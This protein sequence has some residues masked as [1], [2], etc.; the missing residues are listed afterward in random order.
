MRNT[1]FNFFLWWAVIGFSIWL[2]GTLFSMSVIV[3]MWSESPPESVRDFFGNTSF[4]TYIYNFFGPPWMAARNLPLLIALVLGWPSLPHRRYL[5]FAVLPLI[6]GILF[7]LFYIYPINEILMT[8]AGD[9]RSADE[10]QA[11]ADT[12]IFAD[13]LRFGIMLIGYY[14][15]LKAFKLP[16]PLPGKR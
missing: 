15:L 6:A 11:L 12:W 14:F 16:Q 13:R 2:G 3:P 9:G 4:N 8:R 5:L 7:T 1:L 10:I